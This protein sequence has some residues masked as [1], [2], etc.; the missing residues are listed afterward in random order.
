MDR[1]KKLS[2]HRWIC[3]YQLLQFIFFRKFLEVSNIPKLLVASKKNLF[4]IFSNEFFTN[5]FE[6]KFVENES[7]IIDSIDDNFFPDAIILDQEIATKKDAY[8][9][10][11]INEFITMQNALNDNVISSVPIFAFIEKYD[12]K[13][14]KYLYEK[15][16]FD[17]WNKKSNIS[18]ISD[19]LFHLIKI[20]NKEQKRISL[21]TNQQKDAIRHL[22]Q[23]NK[24]TGVYNKQTFIY[25]TV[26]NISNAP[27]EPWTVLMFDL[28]RFKVF[29]DIF[30]FSEGDRILEKIGKKLK[31][32]VPKNATYGHIY[33]D[34]F[35]VCLQTKSINM[36]SIYDYIENFAKTL[37]PKF[38]FIIRMGI[39]TIKPGKTNISK[40]CDHAEM[41]LNSIK[42]D[43]TKHY[44]FYD[45]S[46]IESLKNEQELISDMVHGIEND[47]FHVFLQP[48]YDY[49]TETLIGAE[50]LVRW[51]HPTKGLISPGFFIPI[52]EKNGFITQLDK[53][54]W[55]KTCKLLRKWIDMGLNPV[56]VSV[57]ISRQDIYHTDLI[58]TFDEL[59]K[60]YNLEPKHLRLEI[61]ESAYM[62]NPFQLIEV[63]E[64]LR[65]YGFCLEM[66]DFGSGYSSLNTLKEVPVD[67]LKLDMKFISTHKSFSKDTSEEDTR[68]GSILS[69]VIRMAN[70]LQ[71][72]VLA[73]GIESKEQADYLKSIGCFNMQGYYFAKPMPAEEYEELLM[74]LPCANLDSTKSMF[75]TK[76]NTSQAAK[77][78]DATTQATLLFNSFVGGAAILESTG[79]N[80][81]VL[82]MNDQFIKELGTNRED[83]AKV[84]KQFINTIAPASRPSFMATLQEV[85]HKDISSFCEINMLP[86]HKEN[87]SFWIRLH[88]RHIGKTV[89]SNIYYVSI[90]NIDFRMQLLQM[91]TNLSEQLSTIMESVPC[92]ILTLNYGDKITTSY[93]NETASSILGY[94]MNAF[95]ILINKNPFTF[96]CEQDRAKFIAKI[97]QSLLMDIKNFAMKVLAITQTGSLKKLQINGNIMK[98]TDDS[99]VINIT[100]VDIDES[101]KDAFKSYAST[102]SSIFHEIFIVDF[103]NNTT[104]VIKSIYKDKKIW[105]VLPLKESF[106]SWA[107]NFVINEDKDKVLSTISKEFVMSHFEKLNDPISLEYNIILKDNRPTKL[108]TTIIPIELEPNKFL[109]CNINL[110]Q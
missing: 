22:V 45:E 104:Q 68:G 35:V 71:L 66:D 88:I 72:P 44:A 10:T 19:R 16:F 48:Q 6:V 3:R 1:I 98:R 46:M 29:N 108:L 54:I 32:T 8:I 23:L 12:N 97:E 24:K 36:E 57:N 106:S 61:T 89:T 9:V 5:S 18:E 41:A 75:D 95:N 37:Y 38:N 101:E 74:D 25:K 87:N 13:L 100:Y 107:N 64:K 40:A 105:P 81:E 50:A 49:T 83:Y 62:D 56:P 80:I 17:V 15:D 26:Q 85:T 110:N 51:F 84:Q 4:S 28:D 103:F 33:A 92:G 93:S 31:E 47:E 90:E 82:R 70:W 96:I 109:C 20:H 78:L 102:L 59:L 63:V 58:V 21:I 43:F 42:Q 60:K 79:D 69:S 2:S 34:R 94:K 86:I 55:E 73:E 76:K 39:Y 30:G 27:N 99:I 91:N 67:V 14:Q 65:K 52:F 11:E 7:Q 77:F 53:F